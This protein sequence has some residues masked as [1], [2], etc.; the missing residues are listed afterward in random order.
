MNIRYNEFVIG[1]A[2]TIAIIIVIAGIM[3][4]ERSNFL[5]KGI[6]VNLVVEN[7]EGITVGDE[8]RYKGL[9]VGSVHSASIDKAGIILKLKIKNGIQIPRDSRFSIQEVSL[10]GEK[11]VTIQPGKSTQFIKNGETIRGST[12][13]SLLEMVS[14]S[15]HLTQRLNRILSHIDSITDPHSKQNIAQI[16]SQLNETVRQI[17]MLLT[18]NKKD[19]TQTIHNLNELTAA[20]KAPLDT[21]LQNISGKSRELAISIHRANR[22]LGKLDTVLTSIQAGKGTLGKLVQEETLYRNL[23]QT[24]LH[25]DSLVQAIHKNPDKYLN[26]KVF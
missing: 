1:I 14:S 7:A 20:G 21:I 19:L 13:H 23:N 10:L 22:V 17:N 25:L 18:E 24:I 16:V 12:S 15:K 8:V 4:L 26:V 5:E 9:V 2:V 11:A 6:T 3:W